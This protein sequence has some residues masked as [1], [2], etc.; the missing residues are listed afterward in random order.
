[1]ADDAR[2]ATLAE[3]VE[4]PRRQ[5]V[6]VGRLSRTQLIEDVVRALSRL[7]RARDTRALE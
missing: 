5:P 4:R 7:R 2:G 6:C 3:V 1:M